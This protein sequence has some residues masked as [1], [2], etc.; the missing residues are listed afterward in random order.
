MTTGRWIRR[1]AWIPAGVLG[2]GGWLTGCTSE[3]RV[4]P[5]MLANERLGPMVIAVAPALNLSG[6]SDFDPNQ[7]ADLMASELN[8]VEG[9]GV[10]PVSRVLSVLAV[11]GLDAVESPDHALELTR[12][13]GADAILVFAVTEYGP[14][15]PPII[16]ISAQLYGARP[17][18]GGRTIDPVSLSR[19]G[20][21]AASGPGTADRRILA[22]TQRVFD[23]SH[24]SVVAEIKAFARQR[25]ADESPYGWRK[26]VVSQRN[27]IRFCCHSTIRT[28]VSGCDD[29]VLAEANRE[30]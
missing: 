15:D 6:G 5:A 24:A 18:A 30:R 19:K 14:Y 23:A 29:P 2:V 3:R 27:Y 25:N 12:L 26:H 16:G 21:L 22:R 28:L 20:S 8:N 11:Q 4:G 13:L 1:W 10:V 17:R 9:V 7:F